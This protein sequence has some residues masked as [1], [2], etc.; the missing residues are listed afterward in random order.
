MGKQWS[1]PHGGNDLNTSTK[2]PNGSLQLSSLRFSLVG[3]YTFNNPEP[4]V[5]GGTAILVF[6]TLLDY[7]GT[8]LSFTRKLGN[9][10]NIFG[11]QGFDGQTISKASLTFAAVG[12]GVSAGSALMSRSQHFGRPPPRL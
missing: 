5:F 6:S 7:L 11:F 3:G 4:D 9:G 12:I 1:G 2:Q 10:S 8:A